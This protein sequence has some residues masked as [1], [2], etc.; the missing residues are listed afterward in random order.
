MPSEKIG[1][2][3]MGLNELEVGT[4]P[5]QLS[6][7]LKKLNPNSLRFLLG[8]IVNAQFDGDRKAAAQGLAKHGGRYRSNRTVSAVATLSN[9]ALGELLNDER[10]IAYWHLEIFARQLSIPVGALLLLSRCISLIRDGEHS[11]AVDFVEGVRLMASV[12][13]KVATDKVMTSDQFTE[14]AACFDPALREEQ[15]TLFGPGIR[16]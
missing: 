12:L 9:K 15:A 16:S 4:K 7:E 8:F 6:S 11:K 1:M 2:N 10:A 14:L 5:I 3:L 13:S